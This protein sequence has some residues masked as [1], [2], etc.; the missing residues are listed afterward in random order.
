VTNTDPNL[1]CPSCTYEL[2]G[3][4][5]SNGKTTCP[6][7]GGSVH[8]IPADR[9]FTKKQ[10]HK[11]FFTNAFLPTTIPPA[12]IL[13]GMAFFKPLVIFGCLMTFAFPI[14]ILALFIRQLS[15]AVDNSDRSPIKMNKIM[16]LIWELLYLLPGTLLYLYLMYIILMNISRTY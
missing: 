4:S 1:A 6:E 10:L 2:T 15:S 12:F 9:F 11:Q 13:F 5:L 7:C 14:V 3:L 16:I 8:P